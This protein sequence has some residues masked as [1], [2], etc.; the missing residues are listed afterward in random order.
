MI[1]EIEID[2]KI[3]EGLAKGKTQIEIAKEL[4][5]QQGSISYRIK[6]MRERGIDI[7]DNLTGKRKKTE[8]DEIDNKIL[9]GLSKGKTQTKMEKE[10]GIPQSAISLRIKKM[11]ERGIEIPDN[12]TG[13]R[14]KTEN[15]EID[16][17]ILEG[18]SK[19]KT[20]TKMEKELGIPQ[21]AISLRIKKMR[22]RGIDIP[23]SLIGKKKKTEN[24]EI[25]NKLLEGLSKGKKQKEIAKELGISQSTIIL[26]IKQ[27]K[28]RG[29]KIPYILKGRRKKTKND[30]IDN[31][32]LEEISKGK[33]QKEIAKELGIPKTT[34]SLRIN[35]MRERG[36]DIPYSLKGTRRKI[37]NIEIDNKI[38]EGL[39]KE[40][41]QK[42]IAKELE[43]S[44][45]TISY[46]INRMRKRGIEIPQK[47][48][49][50]VGNDELA[51]K[52]IRL[53]YSR[54]ASKKQL[55]ILADNYGV[56]EEVTKLLDSLD[57][58]LD[59]NER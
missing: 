51:K 31:K 58:N 8:N 57:K 45:S 11:R 13:K 12:L 54:N 7:P 35:K 40:K 25:D 36:T 20:Q 6:K 9:E 10:L 34:V 43:I 47:P 15:D 14:K 48:K 32:I 1:N 4:E 50:E 52:I 5:V 2:N 18:L 37:E 22:E 24:D 16:N 41:Q 38:L 46:R 56:K 3:L 49:L 26:R 29:I 53:K 30:E 23:D 59:K 44:E 19:G 17:K 21:S 42:E 39:S 55:K 28:E 33:K 27:M